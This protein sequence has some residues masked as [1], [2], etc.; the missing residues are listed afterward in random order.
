MSTE[1]DLVNELV[2]ILKEIVTNKDNEDKLFELFKQLKD[3][4]HRNELIFRKTI[5]Q[6]PEFNESAKI[7][8]EYLLATIDGNDKHPYF[9]KR[10]KEYVN[11]SIEEQN[12][13]A[14]EEGY[15]N[16]KDY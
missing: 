4:R 6:I 10:W 12:K 2:P 8:S 11:G 3:C 15:G 16:F 7:M 5:I 13:I 9:I 1:I 14:I